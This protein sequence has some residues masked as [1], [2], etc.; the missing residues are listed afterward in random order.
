MGPVPSPVVPAA[1]QAELVTQPLYDSETMA[2][3]ATQAVFFDG[4]NVGGDRT[5]SNLDTAGSL[6][7]PK[8]YRVGGYRLVIG[9]TITSNDITAVASQFEDV[10]RIL[11]QCAFIFS[12]GSLKPY[13]EVPAFFIPGGVG[14]VL[15]SG[16]T[17]A[18]SLA[19]GQEL[20]QN[21]ARLKH[22]VS[23]PP[24]QSFRVSLIASTVLANT[25][26][27][28]GVTLNTTQRI[29]VFFDGEFGREVM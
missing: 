22:W 29:W 17:T 7:H 8:F 9:P 20:F 2:T 19:N 24:L 10:W 26:G 5:L 3:G 4:T 28:A 15:R 12:I 21:Y 27:N 1:A 14:P 11:F 6:P 23:L 13:M 25:T 16:N 18:Y